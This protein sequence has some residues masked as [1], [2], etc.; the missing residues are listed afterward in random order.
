M[1]HTPAAAPGGSLRDRKRIRARRDLQRAAVTL[2]EERGY[3][4]TTIED[5][6]DAAQVSRSSFFRYFGSKDAVFR[7]D[8]IEEES[9]ATWS[10]PRQRSFDD[11]VGLICAPYEQL[12]QDDW[13]LERRRIEIL[14]SVPDLRPHLADEILRPFPALVAYV[15]AW[16]DEDPGSVHVR[17]V[18]GALFGTIAGRFLPAH[19]QEIDLPARLDDAV[20]DLREALTDAAALMPGLVAGPPRRAGT[21]PG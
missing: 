17:T 2:V 16:L 4:A 5:I 13:D 9:L 1:P 20:A 12:G 18:A 11:L 8:L 15:A 19:G 7:A 10:G 6:C 14:Q 3:A 21:P